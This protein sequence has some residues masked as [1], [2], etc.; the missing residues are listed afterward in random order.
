[1][2]AAEKEIISAFCLFGV[3]SF[4]HFHFTESAAEAQ[5]N[6]NSIFKR[7]NFPQNNSCQAYHREKYFTT[8]TEKVSK[9]CTKIL[10]IR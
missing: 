3:A 2:E 10:I 6:P 9:L 7:A 4:L 5:H 8:T 1:V